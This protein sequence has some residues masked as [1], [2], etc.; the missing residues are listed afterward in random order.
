MYT[1]FIHTYMYIYINVYV[2]LYTHTCNTCVSMYRHRGR[3]RDQR[4]GQIH[5]QIDSREREKEIVDRQQIG[6]TLYDDL[7]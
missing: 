1:H 2:Q 6:K 5:R 7:H 3:D 4:D